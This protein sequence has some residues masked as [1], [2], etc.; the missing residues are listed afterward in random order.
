MSDDV[1]NQS[2]RP[3][4]AAF[5]AIPV[6]L[7]AWRE[8]GAITAANDA[9]AALLGLAREELLA[10]SYWA[11][12]L[13]G[14]RQREIAA[15]RGREAPYDKE[16]VGADGLPFTAR[17]V[18]VGPGE[19]DDVHVVA[20]TA[21]AAAPAHDVEAALRRQNRLL[22][23]LAQS[24]EID[25]GDLA[26]ALPLLTEVAAEGLGCARASVWV[27]G[28]GAAS[29]VCSDLYVATTHA[30]ASGVEL[31][32]RDFP[33]YFAALAENRTIAAHDAHTDPATR[34][35]SGPYLT[36]LGIG[37]MLDAPIRQGGAVK[38]VLCHE[39][40]GGPRRFSQD[41]QNF[42][43][44]LADVV[45]RAL[46][47][48]DRRAAEEALARASQAL[49]RHSARLAAEV[50]ART[51]ELARVG[52]E[53]EALIEQLRR[54]VDVLSSPVIEVWQGV[55]A[56]PVIGTVDAVQSA[57]MTERLLAELTRTRARHAILELTGLSHCDPQTAESFVRTARA[58][59]LLGAE[60]VLSGLQPAAAHTLVEHG[61]DLSRLK[62]RRNLQQA[63]QEIL[64]RPRARA[65]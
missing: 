22:Q 47:A 45:A 32:A 63:L 51:Q 59:E 48:A 9:A 44:S 6:A 2:R 14:Q 11:L 42:A 39:H 65:G 33:A 18:G 1:S 41:E 21:E 34:E 29:I 30:H 61:I 4:S 25:S 16:F 31:L 37:A 54:S 56:V 5:D 53:N 49:E 12:T 17:V 8:D 52:A 36:P 3:R 23:R 62:T 40:V 57:R 60:C 28:P 26:R 7:I 27:Y 55:L 10:R 35:F 38:G 13:P 19:A 64:A 43:A 46:T 15:V 58:V 24:E 50:A 20:F